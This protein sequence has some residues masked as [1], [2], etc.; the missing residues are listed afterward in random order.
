MIGEV[1]NRRAKQAHEEHD[2]RTLG[3]VAALREPHMIYTT[4][5]SPK[6]RRLASRLLLAILA[7]SASAG[8]GEP[9]TA[10]E[11]LAPLTIVIG[12][13][14]TAQAEQRN[15]QTGPVLS[16]TLE[17]KR[18]AVLRA[19]LAGTVLEAMGEQGQRVHKGDLLA[20]LD[21]GS[22]RSDLLSAD[23]AIA[24]ARSNLAST[25]RDRAR[26][27]ELAKAGAVSR[28]D[29]EAANQAAVAAKAQLAQ[30]QAGRSAQTERL[31][32]ALVRAPFDGV[33][34]EKQ[35][36]AGDVVQTGAALYTL[37]DPSSLELEASVAAADL[38]GLRIGAPVVFTVTGYPGRSFQG[39]ITR[40]N[41]VA[42]P[43]TRQV[44]LYAEL[45][46]TT[47]AL[48]SGL[49][50]EGRAATEERL[51]LVV[52]AAAVDRRL[53][54]P[55]VVRLRDGKVERVEVALGLEDKHTDQVEILSGIEASNTL[56]VG[57]AQDL[58]AG[59][60]VRIQAPRSETPAAPMKE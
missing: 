4:W 2:A 58:A 53:G 15:I 32:H 50:A 14:D 28:R 20:R 46:N 21:E 30:A 9:S 11:P 13:E 49:F 59:T 33:I 8:C 26:S 55:A 22:L 23:A 41:P 29:I 34:S 24:N 17:P 16:G 57:A 12:V 31:E 47:G 60:S 1:G 18:Q 36:S 42:D 5:N 45:P 40:I 56:L 7:A 25:Q 52:P 27:S 6:P 37:V 19:Q 35:A 44:R 38:S 48:L 51:T 54:A 43:L 3:S 39:V 10:R